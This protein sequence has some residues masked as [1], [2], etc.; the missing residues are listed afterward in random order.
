MLLTM[1]I[2]RDDVKVDDGLKPVPLERSFGRCMDVSTPGLLESDGNT[3]WPPCKG[4]NLAAQSC[5]W[6]NYACP[7][8]KATP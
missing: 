8:V 5:S 7:V 4:C 1:A 6:S 2:S 3:S